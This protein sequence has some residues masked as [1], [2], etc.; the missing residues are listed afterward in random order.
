ML[1]LAHVICLVSTACSIW[2]SFDCFSVFLVL[3]LLISFTVLRTLV[4]VSHVER[5]ETG[6]PF[7][8]VP[9]PPYLCGRWG[10]CGRKAW[11]WEARAWMPLTCAALHPTAPPLLPGNH[12]VYSLLFILPFAPCPRIS[13]WAVLVHLSSCSL[14]CIPWLVSVSPEMFRKLFYYFLESKGKKHHLRISISMWN[15]EKL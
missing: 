8:L 4:W 13:V 6:F 11:Q 9:L 12:A 10:R 15:F 14:L 7:S 1:T 5:G 2:M 3:P